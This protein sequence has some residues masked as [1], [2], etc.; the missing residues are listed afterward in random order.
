[1]KS[2]FLAF[3]MILSVPAFADDTNKSFDEMASDEFKVDESFLAPA[4]RRPGRPGWGRPQRSFEC[5]SSNITRRRFIGRDVFQQR[6]QREALQQCRR[7]SPFFIARTCRVNQCRV[8]WNR[9][10]GRG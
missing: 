9:G 10:G 7:H 4:D 1:M 6:A 5:V 2:L 3:A 8:V